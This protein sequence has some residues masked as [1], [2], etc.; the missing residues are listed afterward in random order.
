MNGNGDGNGNG[1]GNGSR[2]K[3]LALLKD[4]QDFSKS[5]NDRYW[6]ITL[7]GM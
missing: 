1:N 7:P 6:G 5:V 4:A 2:K 3:L